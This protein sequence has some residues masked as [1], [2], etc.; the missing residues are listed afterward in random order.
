LK[1]LKC[2]SI[3]VGFVDDFTKDPLVLQL[4][5][6]LDPPTIWEHLDATD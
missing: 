5:R 2:G 4:L 1:C 3:H 6:E